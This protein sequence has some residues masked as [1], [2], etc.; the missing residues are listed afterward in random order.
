MHLTL[1]ARRITSMQSCCWLCLKMIARCREAM[2][3]VIRHC[4]IAIIRCNLER[5]HPT[6]K[7]DKAERIQ[8]ISYVYT[9]SSLNET[10]QIIEISTSTVV[11][12][13]ELQCLNFEGVKS[14][15]D[16]SV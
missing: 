10:L 9:H 13:T 7:F 3:I 8:L 5:P 11:K 16:E 6:N 14:Y 15:G 4:Q 12:Y 2:E 1:S